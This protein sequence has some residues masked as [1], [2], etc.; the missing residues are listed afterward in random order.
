M[1]YTPMVIL[2]G[3]T[4]VSALSGSVGFLMVMTK[5][6]KEASV[7]ITVSAVL[8]VVLNVLLIPRLGL[9]GA[10]VSTAAT[11]VLWNLIMLV[12]VQRRLNINST[13]FARG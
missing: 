4:A 11:T 2:I 10:A 13:V 9:V 7:I 1:S 8:N 5:H 6:Q 3:G 12:F